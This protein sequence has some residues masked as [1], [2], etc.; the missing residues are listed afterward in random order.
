MTARPRDY[1]SA[2]AVVEVQNCRN[3]ETHASDLLISLNATRLKILHQARADVLCK[4]I[5]ATLVDPVAIFLA[6]SDNF[7][8]C[9]NFDEVPSSVLTIRVRPTGWAAFAW[10]YERADPERPYLPLSLGEDRIKETKYLK[11]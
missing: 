10:D 3:P 9:R 1:H 8:Y 4:R 2:D 5:R 11:P 7:I 6:V